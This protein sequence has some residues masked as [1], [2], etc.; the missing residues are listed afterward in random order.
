MRRM[1]LLFLIWVECFFGYVNM[2]TNPCT[3]NSSYLGRDT[4]QPCLMNRKIWRGM[5]F[6]LNSFVNQSKYRLKISKN[7]DQYYSMFI[8][9]LPSLFFMWRWIARK[10]TVRAK[11][12]AVREMPLCKWLNPTNNNWFL[13]AGWP[14]ITEFQLL[15]IG[16]PIIIWIRFVWKCHE[17]FLPCLNNS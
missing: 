16:F 4:K 15:L 7:P 5:S 9:N 10:C 13:N 2:Q 8:L 14:I 12:P 11:S 3:C 1:H 6:L 17:H